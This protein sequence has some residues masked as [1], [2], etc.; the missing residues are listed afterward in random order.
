MKRVFTFLMI[1]TLASA[2]AFAQTPD[3]AGALITFE[4]LTH[5]FGKIPQGTPVTYEFT[6]VND[7]TEPLLVTDV[8]KVCGCTVTGW[9]KNPVL[10][11]QEGYVSAQYNAAKVGNFKKP[12]TVI[13]NATNS[14]IKL[15]FEGEVVPKTEDVGTPV[16]DTPLTPSQGN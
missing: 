14:P 15:H 13:S 10:P 11:D 9:T 7:G 1:S 2:V 5:N 4:K 3:Q 6:F 12:V 8:Q 16:N